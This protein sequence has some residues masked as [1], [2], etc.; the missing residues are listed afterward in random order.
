MTS[1][2][3]VYEELDLRDVFWIRLSDT[4]GTYR[5]LVC[6]ECGMPV[7]KGYTIQHVA[8]HEALVNAITR[9]GNESS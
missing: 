8:W 1:Y 9:G 5:C 6:K 3:N 4:V 7:A 2:E